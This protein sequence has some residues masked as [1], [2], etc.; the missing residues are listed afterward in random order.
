[1]AFDLEERTKEFAK[2][3]IRLCKKLPKNAINLEL[4]PQLVDSSGSMAA[5]YREANDAL[6]SKDFVHRMKITRKEAKESH[7][8]LDLILEANSGSEFDS[9]IK[10]LLK[11][12]EELKKIFSAIIDKS[13]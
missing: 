7:L 9:E 8:W 5:N 2:R 6:S 11:E 13:E 12:A 4:I 10:A 3:V 1:M